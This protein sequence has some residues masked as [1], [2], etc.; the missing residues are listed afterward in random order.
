[1]ARNSREDAAATRQSILDAA[2]ELFMAQGVTRTSLAEIAQRAGH[3]RGAIYH[4]FENKAQIMEELIRSVNLP[5]EDLFGNSDHVT[6][7]QFHQNVLRAMRSLFADERRKRINTILFHRCEFVQE[8]NPAYQQSIN[9]SLDLLESTEDVF[10]HAQ[11]SGE[12][13]AHYDPRQ[14]AFILQSMGM[15]LYW[16]FLREPWCGQIE[17]DLETALNVFFSGLEKGHPAQN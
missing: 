10:R 8:M 3:T 15:G 4:H 12:L 17:V 1:M 2:I 11:Q 13:A 16:H 6:L 9:H 14:L 7:G 5:W